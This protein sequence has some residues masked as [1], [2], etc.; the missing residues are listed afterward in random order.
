MVVLAPILGLTNLIQLE[1]QF[2]LITPSQKKKKEKREPMITITPYTL[3]QI[4]YLQLGYFFTRPF[5][6]FL[7]SAPIS[8]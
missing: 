8:N 7:C 1:L 3:L 6:K 2:S 4:P 5:I